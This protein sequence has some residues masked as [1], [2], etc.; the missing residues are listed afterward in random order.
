[1]PAAPRLAALLLGPL[2]VIGLL[3]GLASPAGAQSAAAPLAL[4]APPIQ[5]YTRGTTIVDL[6]LPEATRGPAPLSYTL[7]GP[8]G[9]DLPAGLSFNAG[10]RTLSGTPTAVATSTEL[11]YTV[12]D[13]GSGEQFGRGFRLTV[14]AAPL[15]LTAP[16]DQSYTVDT[17]IT[18]LV[19]PAA[20]A[21]RSPRRSRRSRPR[22]GPT[23][24]GRKTHDPA[25]A[26]SPPSPPSNHPDD[27]SAVPSTSAS[28]P[29]KSEHQRIQTRPLASRADFVNGLIRQTS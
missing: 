14:E 12:A 4:T 22:S 5:F 24:D 8:A 21:G 17:A 28:L 23:E 20:T 18:A 1:M 7:T 26:A 15:A 29:V 6:V 2:M 3:L 25:S 27:P 9:T 19:L 16:D 13:A 11:T 10:T